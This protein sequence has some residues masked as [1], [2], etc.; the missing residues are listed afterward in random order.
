M[1]LLLRSARGTDRAGRLPAAR[2]LAEL[3]CADGGSG[4]SFVPHPNAVSA[5]FHGF[6]QL[7]RF[8]LGVDNEAS[9]AGAGWWRCDKSAYFD[10]QSVYGSNDE[11]TRRI[12]VGDGRRTYLIDV[13]SVLKNA[14]IAGRLASDFGAAT[15]ANAANALLAVFAE[16]HNDIAGKIAESLGVGAPGEETSPDEIFQI[17]RHCN[18]AAFRSVLLKDYLPFTRSGPRVETPDESFQR[19]ESR[20]SFGACVSLELDLLMRAVAATAPEESNAPREASEDGEVAW[21]TNPADALVRASRSACGLGARRSLPARLAASEMNA[22]RRARVAGVCRLNE[23]REARGLPRW[24]DFHSLTAGEEELTRAL[25]ELYG[26]GP[27]AI[28]E[29]ELYTGFLCER[30]VRDSGACLTDT[31]GRTVFQMMADLIEG[32]AFFQKDRREDEASLTEIGVRL[33]KEATLSLL[34]EKHANVTVRG[35]SAFERGA[36][37]KIE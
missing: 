37:A 2:K 26:D 20:S 13:A 15:S 7:L 5:V 9:D 34:L 1:T 18:C 3:H 24:T 29:V 11:A 25:S 4:S 23:F 21:K 31:A 12:R 19:P 30:N 35:V 10:L 33:G 36:L 6:H 27:E 17:A 22:V 14:D 16:N 8:E 28:D 32:D